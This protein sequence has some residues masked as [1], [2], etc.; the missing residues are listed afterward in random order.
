MGQNWLAGTA[1]AHEGTLWTV[2][3]GEL[4]VLA[5]GDEAEP[6]ELARPAFVL[7]DPRD[8]TLHRGHP[9]GSAQN[10]VAA[11]VRSVAEAAG[12]LRVTLATTPA[13]VVEVTPRAAAALE[14]RPGTPVWA[15]F[16][17]T[18]ARAFA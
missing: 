11:A 5:L 17:A 14:L 4:T 15:S 2:A 18:A 7:V 12:P 13:L 3:A 16:K 6:P 10:V 1:T 8:I 9:E